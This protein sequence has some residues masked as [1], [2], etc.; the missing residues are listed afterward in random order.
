MLCAGFFLGLCMYKGRA[1]N[2][3]L[4]PWPSM[5]YCAFLGLFFEPEDR[6]KMFL[7][8]VTQQTYTV[9]YPKR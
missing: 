5:I 3:A 2:P 1:R 7:W 8:N 4:A 9:L 6:A